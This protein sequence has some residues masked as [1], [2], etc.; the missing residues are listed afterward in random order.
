M[1]VLCKWDAEISSISSK[2]DNIAALC[3]DIFQSKSMT[4]EKQYHVKLAL[5]EMIDNAFIHSKGAQQSVHVRINL[6]SSGQLEL[7]VSN[8]PA[9]LQQREALQRAV[10]NAGKLPEPTSETG[11]GL[12]ILF[13]IARELT[14]E[15]D[16]C[17]IVVRLDTM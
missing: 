3:Q 2:R 17:S 9:E 8:Q 13:N 14:V 7:K 15:E 11:R 4:E 5:N 1:I 12:C 10:A 6:S 16:E